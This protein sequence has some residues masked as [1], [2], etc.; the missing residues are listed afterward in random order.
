MIRKIVDY[1]KLSPRLMQQLADKFPDGYGDSDIITFEDHHN[2]I[3]EAVELKTNDTIYLVKVNSKLHYTL[4]NFD[5]LSVDEIALEGI[6][7]EEE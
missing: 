4:T 3:I 1:K 6:D 2:R 7:S 5:N